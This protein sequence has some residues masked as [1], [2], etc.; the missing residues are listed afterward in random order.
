MKDELNAIDK[1]GKGGG[2]TRTWYVG[3]TS[4]S[5]GSCLVLAQFSDRGLAVGSLGEGGL[6]RGWR[7]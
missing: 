6:T 1:D 4:T 5:S 7:D 3:D 2:Q